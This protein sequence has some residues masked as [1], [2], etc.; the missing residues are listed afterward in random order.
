MKLDLIFGLGPKVLEFEKTFQNQN[1]EVQT[2]PREPTK[3]MLM[4]NARKR[5]TS[6]H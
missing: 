2:Y 6:Q 1:C 4:S 5:R 3:K